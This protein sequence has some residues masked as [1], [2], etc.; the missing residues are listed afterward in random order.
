MNHNRLSIQTE[1]DGLTVIK[2]AE[3]LPLA[4]CA[5]RENRCV[6]KIRSQ[7][8]GTFHTGTVICRNE[9]EA[10]LCRTELS[11]FVLSG[12]PDQLNWYI[13]MDYEDVCA[14]CSGKELR[15][16]YFEG[17]T[18]SLEALAERISAEV[19]EGTELLLYAEGTGDGLRLFDLLPFSQWIQFSKDEAAG[20]K[21]KVSIWYC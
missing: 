1:K 21:M 8:D 17:N 7:R 16:A 4:E 3:E 5:V 20:T 9:E 19:S 2:G 10:L 18:A 11:R 15:Y 12:D 14:F 13:G 6:F